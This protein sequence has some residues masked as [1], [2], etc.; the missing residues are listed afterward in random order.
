LIQKEFQ[1][2]KKKKKKEKTFIVQEI[3]EAFVLGQ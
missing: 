1:K 3:S 2:K